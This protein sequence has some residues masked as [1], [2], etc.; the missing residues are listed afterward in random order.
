MPNTTDETIIYCTGGVNL[1]D[2]DSM[3]IFSINDLGLTTS[4]IETAKVLMKDGWVGSLS[5]LIATA[6]GLDN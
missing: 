6:K 2:R 4:E 1:L 5:E 3:M